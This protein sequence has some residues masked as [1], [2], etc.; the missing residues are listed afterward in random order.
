MKK[1]ILL[2]ITII[3]FTNVS[4]AS[5]PVYGE[6][7][8]SIDTLKPDTN[9]VIKKETTE[10][11]HLRMEKQGFDIESCVC[12]SCRDGIA[13]KNSKTV[14]SRS[15][16]SLYK[17]AAILWVLAGIVFAVWILDGVACIND[18]STC[19]S[20]NIPLIFYVSLLMIFGYSSIFYFLKGLS[21]QKRN[22]QNLK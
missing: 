22:K 19:S 2:L 20:N 13:V 10:E 14:N 17:T 12:E 8:I 4:Y 3:I 15:S 18:V 11:Y 9:K 5:F 1:L 7:L 21:V 6:I 16:S